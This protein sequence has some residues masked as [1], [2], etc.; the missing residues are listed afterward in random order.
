MGAAAAQILRSPWLWHGLF[1]VVL[2]AGLITG[3]SI[4]LPILPVLAVV[5]WFYVAWRLV[6]ARRA[7]ARL[8]FAPMP[9]NRT[10]AQAPPIEGELAAPA[11]AKGIDPAD[12]QAYVTSRIIGQDVVAAQLARGIH[13]RMA[14]HRRGKPVFTA[15]LSGPTGTGKTELARAVADYLYGGVMFRVDC[16]NVLGEAGLQTLIGSPKGYAGSGSWGALTA[17]LRSTPR[18][19]LLF[20]EIEKAVTSPNA[21]MAKLL[22]SLLDEGVCTEQSDG[23]RVGAQGAVIL[24]T[25]NAAQDRLGAIF[26][27]FRDEPEQLVRATKDTLRDFFAPEFLA[28]IDLVTTLA[29][30]TDSA[31]ARIIALHTGRIARSYG[32]E[33]KAIDASFVNEAL[34]LWTTLA[35]YGTRE[36]IRWVE[37]ATADE[38]IRAKG[39]GA[40]EV[41]LAWADGAARVTPA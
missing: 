11:E 12:M 25:S 37:D 9:P 10:P 33:L 21:P 30:L 34:R 26:Q 22:L 6:A 8:A 20:D 40:T 2:L 39:E 36:V 29:P 3:H 32:L 23:T 41:R 13:R 17:H 28:R 27:R 31:R 35:G 7:Q 24:L 5:A 16:G 15:L 18:T 19:V 4:L 1:G 38:L 14:Q